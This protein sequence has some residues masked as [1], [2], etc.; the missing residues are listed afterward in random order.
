MAKSTSILGG[1]LLCALLFDASAFSGEIHKAA[2]SGDLAKVQSLLQGDSQLISSKDDNWGMTPLHWAAREGK[3]GVAEFLLS[4]GAD[5]NAKNT[6]PSR[7]QPLLF[8]SQRGHADLANLLL[9]HGANV[10]ARNIYGETA[11]HFAV[12]SGNKSLVELLLAHKANINARTIG[13]TGQTPLDIAERLK[14][15]DLAALL[16]QSGGQK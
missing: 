5:V 7:Q 8:V 15:D 13:S 1:G 11:L 3:I 10:N 6:T 12:M 4:K 2:E 16:R 9:T 14:R